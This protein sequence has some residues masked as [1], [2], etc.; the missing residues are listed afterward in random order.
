MRCSTHA[1]DTLTT[2]QLA[3]RLGRPAST[4]RRWLARG[5]LPTLAAPPGA[6]H[7]AT[8]TDLRARLDELTGKRRANNDTDDPDNDCDG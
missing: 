2:A 1:L 7:R 6:H 4:V 3:Q 8:L 5:I